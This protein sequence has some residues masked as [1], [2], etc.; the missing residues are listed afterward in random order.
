MKNK[1]VPYS[2]V[3]LPQDMYID[4]YIYIYYIYIILILYMYT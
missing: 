2:Y 1:G 3:N 4:I